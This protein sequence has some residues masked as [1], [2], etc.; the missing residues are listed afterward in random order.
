MDDDK[1]QGQHR[2][3]TQA[4]RAT[5][6][7]GQKVRRQREAKVR[8]DVEAAAEPVQP[9]LSGREKTVSSGKAGVARAP[10]ARGDRALAKGRPVTRGR[11]SVGGGMRGQRHSPSS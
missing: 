9:Q 7:G 5:E 10:S 8:E 1:G 3:K 6:S 4:Q 11:P 2:R